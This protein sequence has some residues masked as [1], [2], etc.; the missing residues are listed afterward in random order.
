MYMADN[1]IGGF[2]FRVVPAEYAMH[3]QKVEPFGEQ[4]VTHVVSLLAR[5]EKDRI[6]VDFKNAGISHHT[7]EFEDYMHDRETLAAGGLEDFSQ[8]FDQQDYEDIKEINREIWRLR[9]QG[10]LCRRRS[11]PAGV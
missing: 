10:E 4:P 9:A 1:Q 7:V 11:D 5:G 8:E 6:T 3:H 2:D